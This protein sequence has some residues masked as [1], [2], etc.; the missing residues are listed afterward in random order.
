MTK[1]DCSNHLG[2]CY[3]DEARSLSRFHQTS[4]LLP[5]LYKGQTFVLIETRHFLEII[6]GFM[7]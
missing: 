4:V 2:I 1:D 3:F 6:I 5:L 7:E